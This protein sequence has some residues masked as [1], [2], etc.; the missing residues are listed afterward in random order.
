MRF[1]GKEA[2]IKIYCSYGTK[3]IRDHFYRRIEE[4]V[5]KKIQSYLLVPEQQ[6][7]AY[8]DE[9]VKTLP[10]NAPLHFTVTSFSLLA[11]LAQREYGGLSY[12]M[13]S[14]PI[15]TLFMWRAIREMKPYLTVYG[16]MGI[17]GLTPAMIGCIDELKASGISPDD[18]ADAKNFLTDS[19][20]FAGKIGDLSLIYSAYKALCGKNYSDSND[21]LAKLDAILR[22]HDIF[23]GCEFFI[24]SFTDFTPIQFSVLKRL[25]RRADVSIAFPTD[26]ESSSSLQFEDIRETYAMLK[27]VAAEHDIDIEIIRKESDINCTLLKHVQDNV[28]RIDALPYAGND[29]SDPIEIYRCPDAEQEISACINL[30]KRAVYNGCSFGDVAIISRNPQRYEKMLAAAAVD[31]GIPIFTS[32]RSP[33]SD[34]IFVTY[35]MSLLRIIRNGWRRE[36]VIA[37][38]KC[39]LCTADPDDVHR[40]ELYTS[41]WSLSGKRQLCEAPFN[42][43][44]RSFDHKSESDEKYTESAQRIRENVLLPILEFEKEATDLNTAPEILA[45][46]FA[47]LE[48]VGVREELSKLADSLAEEGD[49]RAA[50]QTARIYKTTVRLFDDV[51]FALG[52]DVKLDVCEA[53]SLLELLF[54]TADIGSIPT[55]QNEV[56]LADAS[57]Y[58]S[59]GHRQII[60]IG[61]NDGAFPRSAKAAGILSYS[62]KE[63]L[64]SEGLPFLS[65][66]CKSASRE[67]LFFWRSI[68]MAKERLILT[69]AERSGSEGTGQPSPAIAKICY[70]DDRIKV[71]RLEDAIP[72][73][74]YDVKSLM[75]LI[76]SKYPNSRLYEYLQMISGEPTSGEKL[77]YSGERLAC[78]HTVPRDEIGAYIG[79][80]LRLSPTAIEQYNKCAFMYFCDKIL[81]L[82]SGEHHRFNARLSGNLVH[83]A[84]EDYLNAINKNGGSAD[85][86]N[87]EEICEHAALSYYNEICPEHLRDNER[88]R[89]AFERTA[90]NAALLAGYV[91]NDL[92]QTDF[93][94]M[95]F[96]YNTA[97]SGGLVVNAD[98]RA[99]INGRIDRI[100]KAEADGE[101]YLR[102][103]DYK[104]GSKEFSYDNLLNGTDLQLPLYLKSVTKHGTDLPGGFLYLS[105]ATPK[106]TV[107]S[108][109][110]LEDKELLNSLLISKIAATGIMNALFVKKRSSKLAAYSNEEIGKLLD[111][112][113]D[114]I[115]RTVNRISDGNF[116]ADPTCTNKKYPCEYCAFA[117][118]CRQR[119]YSRD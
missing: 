80:P 75:P 23:S 65:D 66:A 9:S 19:P 4:N 31:A 28:W 14:K 48:K 106:L 101:S 39:G 13:L 94:P 107:T 92:E 58:R 52:D 21:A 119:R 3:E 38:L 25:I 109:S 108:A 74:L 104:T 59:F 10:Y 35:I 69:F 70:L 56:V 90:I 88:T 29:T 18:L 49:L 115:K 118:I 11:D 85:G 54:D 111:T 110:E 12:K 63:R 105:S 100:D 117:A 114:I 86:I 26:V 67:Y 103:V 96:E 62:E 99:V 57:F 7:L 78:T 102:V 61:C 17:E 84:L 16:R 36:D 24:D 30:I 53:C 45:A 15:K 60:L 97:A 98:R 51:A 72:D 79:D 47:F 43:P 77:P 55:R 64:R 87:A 20:A 33:L 5:K 93:S 95:A 71:R 112:T 34:R 46:V 113:E 89:I 44:Y 27:H 83:K 68:A 91:G 22:E 81:G 2:M 32:D 82:D 41:R 6:V 73:I 1:L 8:E 116:N 76:A 50:D 37:H 40:F 42:A